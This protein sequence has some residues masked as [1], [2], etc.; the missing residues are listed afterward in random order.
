MASD[1]IVEAMV[2]LARALGV[3][4]TAEGVETEE[5]RDALMRIGCDELQGFLLSPPVTASAIDH[6]LGVAEHREPAAVASAA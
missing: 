2:N 5:Q 3:D 6:L 1:A 4:V